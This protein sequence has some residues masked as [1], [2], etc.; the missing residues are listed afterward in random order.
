MPTETHVKDALYPVV[1][2]ALKKKENVDIL[3]RQIS[4]YIDRHNDIFFTLNFSL[5]L[6][7]TDQDK[8]VIFNICNISE[9][10]VSSVI[11]GSADIA[12]VEWVS[13]PFT[14]MMAMAIRYFSLNKMQKEAELC[15]IYITS[16]YYTLMHVKSF[17]FLP[18]KE[19]MDYTL[20][21]NPKLTN[22]F[23]VKKE[24]TIFK[25]IRYTGMTSHEFYVKELIGDCT[26]KELNNY[27]SAIRTRIGSN[28]KNLAKY[29]Y[30]DHKANNYLNKDSDSFEEEN[31]H[32]TDNTTLAIAKLA[33]KVSTNL[34]S[35]RFNRTS[36]NRSAMMDSSTSPT[37][38]TQILDN[39]IE[40]HRRDLDKFVSDIIELYVVEGGNNINEV[41]GLKFLTH[42]LNLYKTNSTRPKVIA[43]KETLDKWIEDGSKKFGSQFVRAATLNAYRKCIFMTFVYEINRN[44]K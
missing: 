10:D 26:D 18:N 39:V 41:A 7:L 15:N 3:T 31:F 43:I 20:N 22:S 36:I 11:K 8:S 28:M 17:P 25:L 44:A 21:K 38:L 13:N 24:G 29:Y 42:S 4:N 5:R 19:T 33:T 35:Y 37:K 9:K 23:I 14:V 40:Y 30:E 1:E 16:L 6:I 12:N 27:L 2:A 34:V 32:L